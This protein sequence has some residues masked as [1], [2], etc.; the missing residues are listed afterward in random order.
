MIKLM[1]TVKRKK[2]ITQQEF[3]RYWKD[4]HGPKVRDNVPGLVKYVQDHRLNSND[5]ESTYDGIAELYFKDMDSF[6]SMNEWFKSPAGSII[7][8]DELNFLD[9]SRMVGYVCEEEVIK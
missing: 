1:F 4:V 7:R 6:N 3:A 8:D 5:D 9:R 2:G